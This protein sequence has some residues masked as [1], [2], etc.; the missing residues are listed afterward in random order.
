MRVALDQHGLVLARSSRHGANRLGRPNDVADFSGGID[1]GAKRGGHLVAAADDYGRFW[2]EPG[3]FRELLCNGTNPARGRGELGQHSRVDVHGVKDWLRPG[4]RTR[5]E[6]GE[7]R[8]VRVIDR[9]DSRCLAQDVRARRHEG[10][11]PREDFRL[12]VSHPEGFEHGMRRVEV[13]ADVVIEISRDHALRQGGGLGLGAAVHPDHRRPDRA[14]FRVADDHA[15]QLRA[16]RQG[17][18]RRW[19]LGD[20]LEQTP[21]ARMQRP[22]PEHGILLG[23]TGTWEYHVIGLVRRGNQRAI[24]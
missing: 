12:L 5:I 8:R 16:E 23:P 1:A 17:L 19:T 4:P 3:G 20:L 13:G 18:H 24:G 10:R 9:E 22:G 2:R 21:D 11:R 6:K 15:V 7:G 14:P